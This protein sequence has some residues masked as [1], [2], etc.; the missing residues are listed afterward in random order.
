MLGV[1]KHSHLGYS[2]GPADNRPEATDAVSEQDM[3]DEWD[4]VSVEETP[5]SHS[6]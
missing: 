5:R 2:T 3:S 1:H 4:V 6:S